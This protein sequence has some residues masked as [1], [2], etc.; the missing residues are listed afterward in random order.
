MRRTRLLLAGECPRWSRRGYGR[1]DGFVVW[2][3]RVGRVL[4][5]NIA[6]SDLILSDGLAEEVIVA[7]FG[8]DERRDGIG[9]GGLSEVVRGLLFRRE[10]D[11]EVNGVCLS[12]VT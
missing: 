12:F 3:D 1:G 11:D 8:C 7:A 10:S 5:R 2:C 6:H 4:Y 9:M